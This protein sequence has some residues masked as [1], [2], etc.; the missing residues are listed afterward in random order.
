MKYSKI[1]VINIFKEIKSGKYINFRG[2]KLEKLRR[3][4]KY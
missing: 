1:N 3:D 2:I 4:F